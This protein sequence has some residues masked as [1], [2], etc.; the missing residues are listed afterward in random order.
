MK[1]QKQLRIQRGHDSPDWQWALVGIA[2]TGLF[3]SL[4]YGGFYG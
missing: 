1:T 2:L 4:I 3:I